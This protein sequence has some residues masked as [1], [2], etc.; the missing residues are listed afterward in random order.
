MTR[1]QSEVW[2]LYASGHTV[3]QI[4]KA[5]CRS[6]GCVSTMLKRIKEQMHRPVNNERKSVPCP[7]SSD[8][9]TCPLNDCKIDQITAEKVN[10]TAWEQEKQ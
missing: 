10:L 8:C 7:Y 5:T 4:A 2:D 1:K 9:F 6:K 3:T